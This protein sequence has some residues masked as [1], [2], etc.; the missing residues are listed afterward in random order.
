MRGLDRRRRA[1]RGRHWALSKASRQHLIVQLL[2]DHPVLRQQQLVELLGARDV[3][4]TRTTVSRD[5]HE[6]GAVKARTPGGRAV[7]TIPERPEARIAP[8][9]RLQSVLR[10]WV[11]DIASSGNLVVLHT[12][13]A[14]AHMVASALDQAGLME[15]VGT[16]AGDDTVLVVADEKT[17]GA[18]LAGRLR[19]L[20]GLGPAS[21]PAVPD[22]RPPTR[23]EEP[24]DEIL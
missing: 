7:Y 14:S 10:D 5:L 23:G 1:R 6:L 21:G 4:T 13:P 17:P 24:G 12:P 19:A 15:V 20:A 3:S 11:A 8:E 16:I 18:R 9:G 22:P 2:A